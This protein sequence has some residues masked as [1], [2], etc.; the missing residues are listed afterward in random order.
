MKKILKVY[1]QKKLNIEKNTLN[2]VFNDCFQQN[3]YWLIFLFFLYTI[4]YLFSNIDCIL[5]NNFF[6]K[7]HRSFKYNIFI[8][9]K[10]ITLLY[11]SN[12]SAQFAW[13]IN[14]KTIKLHNVKII[15]KDMFMNCFNLQ[16][17]YIGKELEEI[18]SSSFQ[19]CISLKTIYI[20]NTIK[21]IH[22][23]A[24]K[25]CISLEKIIFYS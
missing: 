13:C 11:N 14:L 25:N 23:N 17:V 8:K 5:R 24:F 15:N 20:P 18:K 12:K 3:I 22:V 6:L 21:K 19:N 2:K 7:K 1:F 4:K 16:H 9:N 10:S